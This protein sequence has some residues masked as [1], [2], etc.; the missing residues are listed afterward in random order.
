MYKR[1]VASHW[2]KSSLNIDMYSSTPAGT[3]NPTDKAAGAVPALPKPVGDIKKAA[4][5]P[6]SDD[7]DD[8]DDDD[9]D[10]SDAYQDDELPPEVQFERDVF[11]GGW[12]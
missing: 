2:C 10:E 8:D 11:A 5:E 9:S 12:C 6:D 3:T 4:E 1:K 7:D